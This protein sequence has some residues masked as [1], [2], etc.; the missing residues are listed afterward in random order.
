[1]PRLGDVM[2]LTKNNSLSGPVNRNFALLGDPSMQLA[3]PKAQVTLTQ[4]NGQPVAANRPDTLRALQTVELAGE[5][6]QRGGRLSDFSGTLRLTLYDKATTK[7]TLGAEDDSPKMTYQAYTSTIFTGQVP[8]Q[9]GRFTVRFTMPKDINYTVGRAK[10]YA[11]AVRT[12]SLLD[13]LGSYDSLRVGGSGLVDSLDSQP[14]VMTLS[15]VGGITQGDVVRVTGPDVTLQIGLSDNRGINVARSG[16]GHELTAQFGNQSPLILNDA[17][18]AT[19]S[20]G[21]QGEVRYTVRNVASGTY[22]VQVK[23]WDINNNSVEGALSIV[24]SERPGLTLR[25]LSASPNPVATETT[26]TA[27][28]DRAGEPLDWTVGIY[29]FSGRLLHQQTGQCTDCPA[30]LTVGS[31][32]GRTS[33]GQPMPNG[34]YVLQLLVRSVVDGSVARGSGR[35]LLTK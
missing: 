20:D 27:E 12:D 25:A 1:M 23:A 33:A 7:T 3:Y 31:W 6:Q 11:Y 26:L 9:Q 28:L 14:P 5:I 2:R 10:L 15:A 13:A 8:V 19:G 24:V 35:L 4:V 21:R 22:V 18:V 30:A 32:D 34:V 29:D 16:L 17:Y